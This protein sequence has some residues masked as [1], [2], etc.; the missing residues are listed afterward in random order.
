M[1]YH[2][3][4]DIGA[5]SGRHI[6]GYIENGKLVTEE[7]YRFDNGM[8]KT[9][10]GLVWDVEALFSHVLE[11]IRLCHTQNKTPS[12]IAIDT[13]GVDYV[14]LDAEKKPLLP[15]YAYRNEQRK[16]VIPEVEALLPH[17]RLYEKT[18]IQF[19]PFNT[20]YQLYSDK[21]SGKLASAA[22]FM[23]IPDYLAYRLT[24]VIQNE[25]T[26]ATTT[27]LVNAYSKTWDQE[28]LKQLGFPASLFG[29]LT[30]PSSLIGCFSQKIE[31]TLGFSAKVLA[32]PTHD[33]ASAFSTALG[34][35][36]CLILSSGTWSL[37]GALLS[38]PIT[39]EAAQKANFTNEGGI[40][41]TTRFLKN[42][43]GMWLFQSIRR[44]TGKQY[45]YNE[46]MTM[47]MESRFT[48]IFDVNHPSLTAP[49]SMLAAI[50]ALLGYETLPLA[51]LLSSVYHSLAHSYQVA[52]EEITAITHKEYTALQIVGGGSGDTYLNQLTK[53]YTN[54]SVITGPKEA[55]AIGNL[56]S[57]IVFCHNLSR[58]DVKHILQKSFSN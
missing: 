54:L 46:L 45:S 36:D 29:T 9:E 27:S 33:T 26:N 11:G 50:T 58:E 25:Y 48:E 14:L 51:D 55:T 8:L 35:D 52:V 30:P 15:V 17:T 24:D 32:C 19:Q 31:E 18:G 7:I 4:I 1:T 57:Q 47:A 37:I 56:L 6:L 5:S 28:L 2:L 44:E 13:W 12:N 20:I 40:N 43:M 16:A 41:G 39:N 49:E 38:E 34:A 42:I 22:Y 10:Q 3:A 23:Q 21:K 53:E